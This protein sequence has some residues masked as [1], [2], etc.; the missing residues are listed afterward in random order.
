MSTHGLICDFGRHKGTPYTRIPVSY[1]TWMINER[2]A[3]A[4]LA[5]LELERRGTPTPDL[6]VSG[7]AIDRASL[8]CRTV[9]LETRRVNEGLYSWLCRNAREAFDAKNIDEKGRHLHA[10]MKFIFETQGE[11]PVLKT[12]IRDS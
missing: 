3:K 7:H 6:D 2:H 9:W 5:K 1:L 10:G 11:W 8:S 12:V 4:H